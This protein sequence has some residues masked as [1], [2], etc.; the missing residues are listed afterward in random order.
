MPAVFSTSASA[1]NPYPPNQIVQKSLQKLA[2]SRYPDSQAGEL[3]QK[4]AQKLG[5]LAGN[6]LVGNGTTEL[7]R[8]IALT[9]FSRGDKL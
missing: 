8:L 7:I 2:F 4:L 6:I 9:Y 5:I 3:R 1:C